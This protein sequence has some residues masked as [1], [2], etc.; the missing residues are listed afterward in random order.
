MRN[1]PVSLELNDAAPVADLVADAIASR[2]PVGAEILRAQARWVQSGA[3]S[4]L[5]RA[6]AR[7]HAVSDPRRPEQWRPQISLAGVTPNNLSVLAGPDGDHLWLYDDDIVSLEDSGD[8]DPAVH[9]SPWE[10]NTDAAEA[11]A[12][13]LDSPARERV[14]DLRL[15]VFEGSRRIHELLRS[16]AACSWVSHLEL[17]L[18]RARD[19]PAVGERFPALRGLCC[20]AVDLPRLLRR[21]APELRA[22]V[23]IGELADAALR[24]L[25]ARAPKLRHLALQHTRWT[26]ASL[27]ALLELPLVEQLTGL[28]LYDVHHATRFPFDALLDAREAWTHLRYLGLGGHLVRDELRGPFA[29]HPQVVFI[30]H[31][32]RQV[33]ALDLETR[34]WAR[35]MR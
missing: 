10:L 31:D 3:P 18:Q 25:T 29:A 13:L 23:V 5:A 34:G 8:F 2:D 24:S 12:A 30:G 21:G 19:E 28:E 33:M 27:R 15:L 7:V 17:R 16:R 20:E 22:L 9:A 26:D 4:A 32:R 11:L 35:N 6:G 14:R 1:S